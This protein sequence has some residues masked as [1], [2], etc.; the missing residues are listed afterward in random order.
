LGANSPEPAFPSAELGILILNRNPA[1]SALCLEEL[2]SAGLKVRAEVVS[3]PEGFRNAMAGGRYDVILAEDEVADGTGIDVLEYLREKGL[4]IPVVLLTGAVGEERAVECIHRG[5]SDCV[6]KGRLSRLPAAVRLALERRADLADRKRAQ[7][8]ILR[9]S[10]LCSVLSHL[11]QAIVRSRSRD[12][13]LHEVCRIAVEDGGFRMAWAG[14][15]NKETLLVEPVAHYGF[16]DGY[17]GA[18]RISVGEEP[19]GSGPTGSALRQGRHF[20]CNDIPWDAATAPWREEAARRGYRSSAA[21]PLQVQGQTAGVLSLYAGE[22]GFFDS[23]NVELL[24]EVADDVSFALESMEREVQR[25]RAEEERA[26]LHLSEQAALA[27]AKAEARFHELLEAAPDAILEVDRDGRILL[28]NAATEK[29]FGFSREELLGQPVET[30]V[31]ESLRHAHVAHR[32]DYLADPASRP[33]T[34]G[35]DVSARRKDGTEFPV[36][37]RLSPIRSETGDLVTCIVRDITN[38]KRAERALRESSR[39]ISDILESIT[40]AFFALDREWRFTYLNGKAEQF[41]GRRR[42]EL[43]GWNVWEELPEL[44]GTAF[45]TRCREAAA[46]SVPAEFTAPF[47][48][49]KIWAEVH[50]YPSENGLSVYFQ[51]VT[52]RKQ[53]EEQFRQSQKLEALGRLAGG[54]AHD[55]NNLLTIIGGYGQMVFDGLEARDPLRKDMEAVVEAANRASALTR[56][57]LA[58]SRRQMVQPKV[59]D[60]NRLVSKVGKMLRRVIGEDI[61]LRL[62]LAPEA[63]RV[64]ADPGQLEQVLMNLALN[65]RDAMPTGGRLNIATATAAL[66]AH[67]AGVPPDLPAGTYVV[68]SVTDTGTGMDAEVRSQLFEPFFTTKA[69][70]KGT[71]LGL[72]T[73]YGVVKQSGGDILVETELGKGTTFRIYLPRVERALRSVPDEAGARAPRRGTESILLVEDEVEVRKLACE[74][75][76]SQGYRV[77]EASDGPDALRV[78]ES[79]RDSID[80]LITDVIMPLMSGAQ[81]AEALTAMQPDLKVL[82]ISGY[83]DEVIARHGVLG[84]ETQLLQKPFSRKAL[85]S[86]IRKLLDTGETPAGKIRAG[87]AGRSHQ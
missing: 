30:L 78:W 6:L 76:Q 1:D 41:I 54:V 23:E 52:A 53:L 85:G 21:F 44:A 20:V 9:L 10:R 61:E 74:M 25:R 82:Y 84:A 17:L 16:E 37:I 29:L 86:K 72:A 83:T 42:E 34:P 19:E 39:Q 87:G 45:E 48:A 55:F 43:I 64:K 81:L 50:A 24:E 31:P 18:I 26:R 79:N 4:D 47:P 15:V 60:L 46:E 69:K 7:E 8:K 5:A 77:L 58:F 68:L 3:T 40:D 2:R 22:P 70:G 49:R 36:E 59:L 65:A 33:V 12:S 63:A 66:E 27:Q 71:G 57:L 56:Q 38:R 14:L 13:L 80:L 67:P 28:A 51:D 75:L 32:A 62:G 35:C 73:V 11:G